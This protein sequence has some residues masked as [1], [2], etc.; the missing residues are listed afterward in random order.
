MSTMDERFPRL[1][2]CH[3]DTACATGRCPVTALYDGASR[4]YA[5]GC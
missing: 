3:V 2:P 5:C 4:R 1:D